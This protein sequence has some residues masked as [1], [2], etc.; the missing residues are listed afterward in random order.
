[1]ATARSKIFITGTS[2]GLGEALARVWLRRGHTVLGV[3]RR[4]NSELSEIEDYHE[5]RAD[6]GDEDGTR[7]ACAELLPQTD[8]LDLVVLNAGV[9]SEF[10]DLRDASR[11]E[12]EEVMAINLWSNQTLLQCLV[13][14]DRMPARVVAISSGA[15]VNGRRG[16]GG[17][18]LSKAALNMLV[19]LWSRESEETH[20]CA[21]APGLIDTAMQDILCGLPEDSRFDSLGFLRDARGT[22]DMPSPSELAE[23]LARL[24][25]E[26]DRY[27]E[28]GDFLDYRSLPA[29]RPSQA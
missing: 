20:F 27:C 16:W 25:F 15:A 14:H 17:Y 8:S 1:M 23:D 22:A 18:A 5:S 12:L 26:L 11:A 4:G 19:Q 10:G 24:C 3:S 7:R 13:E 28:S 29:P 21:L 6:L 9:L 2:S